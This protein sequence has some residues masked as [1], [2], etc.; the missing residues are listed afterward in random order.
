MQWVNRP[1]LDFRGFSGTIVSGSIRPGDR[2]TVASSGKESNVVRLVTYD[3]DLAEARAGEP[4]TI[5]LADE[6]DVARGDVLT[7]NTERPEVT[8]QLAAH[9]LWMSDDPML[10]G[11]PT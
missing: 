10:R 4:V 3:G 6:V 1:N 11:V 8:D 7:R 5:T 9:I 2:V